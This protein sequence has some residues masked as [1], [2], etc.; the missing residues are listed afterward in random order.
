[1]M[2]VKFNKFE[3]VA[4]FFVLIALFGF[5]ISILGVAVRQGW[6]ES[7]TTYHVNFNQAD[8]VR[9]GT[10]VQVAG[11]K[12][13][14]V[15]EVDLLEDNTIYVKF[16][17]LNKFTGRI[18]ENS[19]VQLIR[20]FVIGERV[21]EITAGDSK[22]PEWNPQVALVSVES[23]DL[24]TALSGRQLGK[25]LEVFS[26]MVE[27]LK[28]LAEAFADKDRTQAFIQM[29][30]R[31]DPLL[32]NLNT[33]S[34]EMI[35]LS[36][37]ATDD[38]NLK[39]VMAGLSET[40]RELNAF[41][42]SISKNAP[43]VAENL[44]ELVD[45]LNVLTTEFKVV[46][47]ALAEIAPELPKTSRRAVEALDEAVVLMKALQKS[48]FVKGNAQEVRLEEAERESKRLPATQ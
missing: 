3:R 35:K 26:K 16:S 47:P 21:L 43:H 8:G 46:L 39:V 27:N 34:L 44:A 37:Q 19:S 42:P 14:S 28:T 5:V 36:R 2:K 4:G 45:N 22:V 20:P 6:F 10:L 12:A 30:D 15:D 17:V 18:R 33:M 41:L 38:G 13:G 31:I 32:K 7:K 48:F 23:L 29:F 25:Q 24:M 11:L 9:P 40:T 1:M